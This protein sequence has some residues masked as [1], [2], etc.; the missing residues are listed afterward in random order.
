MGLQKPHFGRATDSEEGETPNDP[1]P[2]TNET[3]TA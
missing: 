2:T 3:R 1:R